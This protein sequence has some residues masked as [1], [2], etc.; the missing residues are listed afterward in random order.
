[1]GGLARKFEI[2]RLTRRIGLNPTQLD[3][4]NR[5][6]QRSAPTVLFFA[7]L[8]NSFIIPC[9]IAAGL[10]KVSWRRWFLPILGAEWLWTGTLV[11]AG[12]YSIEILDRVETG[13]PMISLLASVIFGLIAFA[14]LWKRIRRRK[15]AELLKNL[16]C[17]PEAQDAQNSTADRESAGPPFRISSSS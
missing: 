13:L 15:T 3:R 16:D 14:V 8:F 9:L 12:Y 7:K 6:V 1:L 10:S 4:L 17:E 11:I 5:K 2:E